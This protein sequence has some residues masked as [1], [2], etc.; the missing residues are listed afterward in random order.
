MNK[1]IL[2]DTSIRHSGTIYTHIGECTNNCYFKIKE[3][4]DNL[5]RTFDIRWKADMRAIKHWQKA[6]PGK[7]NIWPD[8]ADMVVWL[9]DQLE[10]KNR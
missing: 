9:L 1:L 5:R 6:H 4:L 10:N 7:E 8:H 2:G 3:E